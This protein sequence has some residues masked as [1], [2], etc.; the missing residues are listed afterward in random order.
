MLED[1]NDIYHTIPRWNYLALGLKSREEFE[2]YL[3]FNR[4]GNPHYN[5]LNDNKYKEDRN[6]T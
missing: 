5:P 3:Y 6:V 1:I 2:I 4:L